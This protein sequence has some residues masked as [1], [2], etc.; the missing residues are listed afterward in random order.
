M[1]VL[2]REAAARR[3]R[4]QPSDTALLPEPNDA[5]TPLTGR[6]VKASI[7]RMEVES[8]PARGTTVRVLL[9]VCSEDEA[10]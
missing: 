2:L 9:P 7:S 8:E 4:F 10:R 3:G 6:P 5:V 1:T